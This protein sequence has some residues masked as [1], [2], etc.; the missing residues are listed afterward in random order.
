VPWL[1]V[2]ERSTSEIAQSPGATD[3][4]PAKI[5]ARKRLDNMKAKIKVAQAKLDEAKAAGR[6]K[7][8]PT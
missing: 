1:V 2:L 3:S 4:L 6:D 7:W 8:R 5:G